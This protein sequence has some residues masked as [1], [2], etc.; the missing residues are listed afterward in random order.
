[1]PRKLANFVSVIFNPLLMPTI[2]FV[3]I[4]NYTPLSL[5]FPVFKQKA[6]FLLS[7]FVFTFVIPLASVV[8]LGFASLSNYN[9]EERKKRV[10]PFT[11]VSIFYVIVTYFFILRLDFENAFSVIFAAITLAI[12]LSTLITWFW[13]ISIHSVGS[14]G[15]VGFILAFS[16]KYPTGELLFPLIISI[17]VTGLVISARLS[18]NAHKPEETFGGSLLGFLVCYFAV[19]FFV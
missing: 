11:F 16:Y 12:V 10:V 8:T 4:L 15:A 2:I 14:C 18:L 9:F 1:M 3:V 6:Y 7:I 5:V 13:K 19:H 17:L